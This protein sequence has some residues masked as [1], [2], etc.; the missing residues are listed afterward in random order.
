MEPELS[1]GDVIVSDKV[2]ASTIKKGDIITYQGIEGTY[3]NKTITHRVIEVDNTEQGLFFVTKGDAN[4]ETDP[5]VSAGQVY[6]KMEFKVPIIG[7]LYSF[8]MT[9][10][11]LV[12]VI[13]IILL[14]FSNEVITLFRLARDKVH[15][16]VE[17]EFENKNALPSSEDEKESQEE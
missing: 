1:L 16:D 4:P 8:F 12:A 11:G 10:Y 15:R 13:L 7:T 6:G 14:A 3:A 5:I 17:K 2:D 9:P